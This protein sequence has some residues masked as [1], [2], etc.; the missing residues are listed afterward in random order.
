MFGVAML[1]L[2]AAVVSLE[3]ERR[4]WDRFGT[5]IALQQESAQVRV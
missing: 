5:F 2:L 3:S 4:Q 1:V